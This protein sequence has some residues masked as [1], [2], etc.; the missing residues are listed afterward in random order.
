MTKRCNG[1]NRNHFMIPEYVGINSCIMQL[2]QLLNL[3]HSVC[4]LVMIVMIGI[5]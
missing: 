2:F 1:N 4:N 5:I 3:Q